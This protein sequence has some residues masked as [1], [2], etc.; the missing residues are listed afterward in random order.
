MIRTL[1]A[2]TAL[3]AFLTTSALSTGAVAQEAATKADPAKAASTS[4]EASKSGPAG[5]FSAA[6]EQVLATSV[7][8]KTVYTGADEQGE[9][10]G[11]APGDGHTVY[12]R[13]PEAVD[14]R[15]GLL[16]RDVSGV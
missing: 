14:V 1:M 16:M 7:L 12:V 3:A 6:P 2:T 11:V 15:F 8:G 4:S 13:I 9:A 5:Y 10:I